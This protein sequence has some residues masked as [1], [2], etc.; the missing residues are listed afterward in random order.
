MQDA[1]GRKGLET[2]PVLPP[3]AAPAAGN[4][5]ADPDAGQGWQ[6][7]RLTGRQ[8]PRA[9]DPPAAPDDP[10]ASDDPADPDMGQG[11]QMPGF[12]GGQ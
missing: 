12:G 10:A 8:P 6:M 3:Q 7:S 4:S 9:D 5:H 1:T 11:W 2:D